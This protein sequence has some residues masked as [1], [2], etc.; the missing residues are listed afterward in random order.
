MGLL[1]LF[2]SF[3]GRINRRP[4]VIGLF[5]VSFVANT[6][7]NIAAGFAGDSNSTAAI[8]IP[9]VLLNLLYWAPFSALAAKR[10]H[11]RDRSARPVWYFAAVGLVGTA[12]M[13]AFPMM[14]ITDEFLNEHWVPSLIGLAVFAVIV[15][16]LAAMFGRLVF[17]RGTAGPNRYG[18]D[19]LAE[20]A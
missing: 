14:G 8:V 6:A 10:F 15:M 20:G 19:P 11:D 16:F 3:E 17:D 7:A 9:T 1:R 5:V 12:L 18:P 13:I 4:F 2:F